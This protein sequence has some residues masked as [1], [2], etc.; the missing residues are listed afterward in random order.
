MP[1][2]KFY[3]LMGLRK[4][5]VHGFQIARLFY[6]CSSACWPLNVPLIKD[7]LLMTDPSYII[8]SYLAVLKCQQVN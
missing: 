4:C 7:A 1:I 8:N 5:A 3:L 2:E 6:F